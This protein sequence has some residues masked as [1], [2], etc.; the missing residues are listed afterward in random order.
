MYDPKVWSS[1]RTLYDPTIPA[2]TAS[3]G[4]DNQTIHKSISKTATVW[5][6]IDAFRYFF[7]FICYNLQP[8]HSNT[9]H[10]HCCLTLYVSLCIQEGGDCEEPHYG[11]GR[12]L[13]CGQRGHV[14]DTT[15]EGRGDVLKDH[16]GWYNYPLKVPHVLWF[17]FVTIDDRAESGL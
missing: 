15:Q 16:R 7:Q 11:H 1:Y 6:I 10:K 5:Q 13:W 17:V 3:H 14:Q 4:A 8:P 9:K 2:T 12:P